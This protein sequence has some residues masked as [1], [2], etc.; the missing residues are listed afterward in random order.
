MMLHLSYL[1]VQTY[2]AASWHLKLILDD[3]YNVFSEKQLGLCHA[4]ILTHLHSRNF[5][6]AGDVNE[7]NWAQVRKSHCKA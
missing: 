4:L 1:L 3:Q 2:V 5:C 7:T 6:P